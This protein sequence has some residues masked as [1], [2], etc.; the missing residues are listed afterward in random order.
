MNKL[1]NNFIFK[2]LEDITMN[3]E[4]F[5][6][7]IIVFFLCNLLAMNDSTAQWQ[8]C[9]NLTGSNNI[10][11][12]SIMSNKNNIIALTVYGIFQ[13]SDE[14]QSWL[15]T[16]NNTGIITINGDNIYCPGTGISVST[17]YGIHWA[18]INDTVRTN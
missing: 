17:D 6:I 14:G 9:R 3:N 11:I 1:Y 18:Q 10:S 7:Y 12:K 4:K 5:I 15:C 2:N 8:K 13:S 16:S